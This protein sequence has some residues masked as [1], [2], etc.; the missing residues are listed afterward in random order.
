MISIQLLV[1]ASLSIS[2]SFSQPHPCLNM[3]GDNG[4]AIDFSRDCCETCQSADDGPLIIPS[5]V[6]RQLTNIS[7]E[8]QGL[9]PLWRNAF[10]LAT[11]N[12]ILT[13]EVSKTF[14]YDCITQ[15]QR[16]HTTCVTIFTL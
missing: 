2:C 15:V 10:Y 8:S 5:E 3:T 9:L 1:L 4:T 11:E 6:L 13:S 16:L 7:E 14:M 12:H